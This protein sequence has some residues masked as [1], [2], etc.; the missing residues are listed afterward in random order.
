MASGYFIQFTL[1]QDYFSSNEARIRYK[2]KTKELEIYVTGPADVRNIILTPTE[3][4]ICFPKLSNSYTLAAPT[5][6][7]SLADND[8]VLK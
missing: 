8:Y 1:R 7:S 5:V 2:G 3:I 4:N 6:Y